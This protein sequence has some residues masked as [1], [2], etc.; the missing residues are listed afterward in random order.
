MKCILRVVI[1]I[2]R[3]TRRFSARPF[4]SLGRRRPKPVPFHSTLPASGRVK[5]N[6]D[7]AL[8]SGFGFTGCKMET[9]LFL[10]F[11]RGFFLG[12]GFR[13]VVLTVFYQKVVPAGYL[14]DVAGIY[15]VAVKI[16][17]NL[18]KELEQ[19]GI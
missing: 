4:F 5:L 3:V 8:L 18:T 12:L 2:R 14:L 1:A 9:S 16:G 13:E 17:D 11:L 7:N 19:F 6:P 15:A 10:C